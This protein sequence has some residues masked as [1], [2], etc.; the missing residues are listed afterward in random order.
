VA[1][2][3]AVADTE[4][5]ACAF[6][7]EID[8]VLRRRHS[9]PLSA[10][11]GN[12]EHA[13]ILAVGVDRCAIGRAA[14]RLEAVTPAV[15]SLKVCRNHGPC[16]HRVM[17]EPAFVACFWTDTHNKKLAVVPIRKTSSN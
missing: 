5:F 7:G 3:I 12:G 9:S 13:H 10:H 17:A 11:C 4:N 2:W 1:A 16:I 14:G 8:F 15:G 6:N